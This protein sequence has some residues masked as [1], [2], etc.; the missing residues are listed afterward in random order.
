MVVHEREPPVT[1]LAL[2]LALPLAVLALLVV[3]CGDDDEVGGVMPPATDDPVAEDVAVA[4]TLPSAAMEAEVST[5]VD[6]GERIVVQVDCDPA[7]GGQLLN[8]G[9]EGFTAGSVVAAQVAPDIGELRV[10]IGAAG[11]GAQAVQTTLDAATYEVIV[12]VEDGSARLSVD[13]CPTG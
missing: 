6:G 1:R 10:A 5:R 12:P 9:L 3:A 8:L 11:A 2:P 13:G 4:P 7:I